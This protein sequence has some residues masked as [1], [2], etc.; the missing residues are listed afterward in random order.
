MKTKQ[1]ILTRITLK[2]NL[3]LSFMKKLILTSLILLSIYSSFAQTDLDKKNKTTNSI[4]VKSEYENDCLF[5][6]GI[7]NS[8][9]FAMM[10]LNNSEFE[11][12][13]ENGT[14]KYN[15]G[16]NYNFFYEG[17]LTETKVK[18]VS[19][20]E[21]KITLAEFKFKINQLPKPKI[22]IAESNCKYLNIDDL[23][24]LP[25]LNLENLKLELY[26]NIKIKSFQI[27]ITKNNDPSTFT[28]SGNSLN[29]KLID[30]IKNYVSEK[31]IIKLLI[32]DIIAVNGNAILKINEALF[33]IVK[34]Q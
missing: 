2:I 4:L 23:L 16:T 24:K 31:G 21:N 20:A 10:G 15:I 5:Y 22:Q 1:K 18:V 3:K 28:N 11:I 7:N 30:E 32:H 26:K 14:I 12:I 33:Y 17:D 6:N 9:E 19:K 13:A 27:T 29:S 8:F 25:Y 34:N